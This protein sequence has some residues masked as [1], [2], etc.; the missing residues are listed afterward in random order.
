MEAI[1]GESYRDLLTKNVLNP[2]GMTRTSYS[3]PNIS[4]GVIPNSGG[5]QWWNFPMGDETP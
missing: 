3:A 1:A 5:Q 2:L 4:L